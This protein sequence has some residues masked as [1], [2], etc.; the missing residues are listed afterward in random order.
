[1]F[2][3]KHFLIFAIAA[4]FAQLFLVAC[5][6]PNPPGTPLKADSCEVRACGTSNEC[7]VGDYCNDGCCIPFQ[8]GGCE[9]P[10]CL[11]IATQC[12][13]HAQ[14]C[15]CNILN[16]ASTFSSGEPPTIHFNE[17]QRKTLQAEIALVNGDVLATTGFQLEV[18]GGNAASFAID[19]VTV[20]ATELQGMTLIQ[21]TFGELAACQALLHN[22]G[23]NQTQNAIR[24]LAFDQSSG[25]GIANA[26]ITIDIRQNRSAEPAQL[27]EHTNAEGLAELHLEDDEVAQI[28]IFHEKYDYV[29]VLN[30][31]NASNHFIRIPLRRRQTSAYYGG[32]TG[33]LNFNSH[34]E[35]LESTPGSIRLG[36]VSTSF[37]L[38]KLE[39]FSTDI[40][41]G[42]PILG[43]DCQSQPSNPGCYDFSLPGVIEQHA[44]VWG[45][46][47][48]SLPTTP[49]KPNFQ[50]LGEPGRR[51]I[52]GM[53]GTWDISATASIFHS[54][55]QRR[56]S[57][58]CP[59]C[60]VA[61]D[62]TILRSL[63]PLMGSA[64]M[65]YRSNVELSAAPL[66]DW[67][68][69]ISS[70]SG[71]DPR[72]P[73]LD[74]GSD[75]SGLELDS[76]MTRFTEIRVPSLPKDPLAPDSAAFEGVVVMTGTQ[77]LGSGFVPR[78][79]GVGLDCLSDE[80]FVDGEPIGYDGTIDSVKICPNDAN[81]ACSGRT[82][83]QVAAG[84][85]ALFHRDPTQELASQPQKTILMA[86][87]MDTSNVVNFRVRAVVIDGILDD[88]ATIDLGNRKFTEA[89][90]ILHVPGERR[91]SIVPTQ[92]TDV[93]HVTLRNTTDQQNPRWH[94]YG[95]NA[96]QDFVA[97][98]TPNGFIDPFENNEDLHITHATVKL[99]EGVS[100][101]DL[102]EGDEYAIHQLLDSARAFSSIAVP[103]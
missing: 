73:H 13:T 4:T 99:R 90:T 41:T 86:L 43:R 35:N 29:S 26:D 7:P 98:N 49:M 24:V 80:C 2:Q 94:I 27:N 8:L 77:T 53:G 16:E 66:A 103:Q 15:E 87:P 72:F 82:N 17:G 93:H 19:N 59:A 54:L 71:P 48:L 10:E 51:Y 9:T 47:V 89:P 42:G 62:A 75:L 78:G 45:G 12:L 76:P 57:E 88:D 18:A 102:L 34:L 69:N 63:L 44:A 32:A 36:M 68:D 46:L 70:D 3:I 67:L 5:A 101:A 65:G 64:S 96:Q 40:F 20:Q 14:G 85:V 39:N 60:N 21:A 25:E 30:I 1:M 79:I 56:T 84:H 11:N 52:W 95:L 31:S 6:E 22:H 23:A 28:S 83:Y 61:R 37:P 100:Y 33:N 58:E 91:Y 55:S 50:V 92:S 74:S 81:L 38:S 97:P